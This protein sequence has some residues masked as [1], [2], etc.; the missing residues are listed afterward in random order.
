MEERTKHNV[1]QLVHSICSRRASLDAVAQRLRTPEILAAFNKS[2]Y[3]SWCT[4]VAGDSLVRLRIFTEQNFNF[5]ETI[6]VVAV[7]RYILE[8]SVWLLLFK[9]DS[10]YGLVYYNQLLDTQQRYL[11]A[12]GAQLVREVALLRAFAKRE[13][14]IREQPLKR[15]Q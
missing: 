7:A 5:I 6:G 1:E 12:M 15:D 9:L 3:N 10:R 14:E 11:Q 4:S 8:M 13:K 2:D